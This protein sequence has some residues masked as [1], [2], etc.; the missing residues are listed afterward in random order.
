MKM[1]F[2]AILLVLMFIFVLGCVTPTPPD[3]EST[4]ETPQTTEQPQSTQSP[5][6]LPTPK[7]PTSPSAAP[8][9]TPQD[10]PE[11]TPAETEDYSSQLPNMDDLLAE[12]PFDPV[13]CAA[14]GVSKAQSKACTTNSECSSAN[15]G[16]EWYCDGKSGCCETTNLTTLPEGLK[17][18]AV[19]VASTDAGKATL[20]MYGSLAKPTAGEPSD[21]TLIVLGNSGVDYSIELSIPGTEMKKT[22]SGTIGKA[23]AEEYEIK[24]SLSSTAQAAEG[25]SHGIVAGKIAAAYLE[26]E[27]TTDGRLEIPINDAPDIKTN[28]IS[29]IQNDL[30]KDGVAATNENLKCFYDTGTKKGSRLSASITS[31]I[32][33]NNG[34]NQEFKNSTESFSSSCA[35]VVQNK[36]DMDRMCSAALGEALTIAGSFECPSSCPIKSLHY[37]DDSITQLFKQSCGPLKTIG[38]QNGVHFFC[39]ESVYVRCLPDFSQK[40]PD[41]SVSGNWDFLADVDVTIG[42]VKDT[43]TVNTGTG[44]VTRGPGTCTESWDCGTWSGWGTC[45]NSSQSR[46]RTCT[47]ANNC[48]TTANKPSTSES[49]SCGDVTPSCTESWSC[50]EYGAWGAWGACQ[51]NGTQTRERA[52]TCTDA[53]NCGTTTSK[54]SLTESESQSCAYT[55]TEQKPEYTSHSA[56]LGANITNMNYSSDSKTFDLT[57]TGGQYGYKILDIPSHVTVKI[58]VNV[59]SGSVGYNAYPQYHYGYDWSS[60]DWEA[61]NPGCIT[62][63]NKNSWANGILVHVGDPTT[64][65]A[66]GTITVT[67]Q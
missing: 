65:N 41:V 29:S 59:S 35:Q 36:V 26:A 51:E 27:R 9:T 66:T 54:P 60:P 34:L 32:F 7:Q 56:T 63:Y 3:D 10:V 30:F 1:K 42:T 18:D 44:D 20:K 22:I 24:I 48:G 21:L 55:P 4:E 53:N 50:G 49:R 13:A 61:A 38:T 17:E 37:D 15:G 43:F 25:R 47:D 23:K 64:A 39:M 45:S 16:S 6:T 8:Q 57:P 52:R 33:Y 46:T 2:I 11:E 31:Q 67:Q 12:N 58:C 40:P 19:L 28:R 5:T 62:A 14:F